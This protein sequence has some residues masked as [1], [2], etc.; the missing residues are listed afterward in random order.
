MGKAREK[1]PARA[2]ADELLFEIGR[3][4]KALAAIE[5]ELAGQIK[6]LQ[7]SYGD[8]LDE[9]VVRIKACEKI[10]KSHAKKERAAIFGQKD[11]A[12]LD[13]GALIFTLEKRVKRVKKMVERL[14]AAGFADAIKIAESAN[15]DEIEKWDDEK[16]AMVGTKRVVKDV[17]AYETRAGE[18]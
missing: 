16:L 4:K 15:W 5:A 9:L 8:K 18:L 17:F 13:H 7:N 12:D 14:K 3:D 2:L 10:L 1:D 11:R 6:A